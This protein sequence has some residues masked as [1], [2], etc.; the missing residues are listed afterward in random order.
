MFYTPAIWNNIS[1]HTIERV[2]NEGNYCWGK[3]SENF[4]I[5][6]IHDIPHRLGIYIPSQLWYLYDALNKRGDIDT[7][8]HNANEK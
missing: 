5:F 3:S 7:P 8:R 6:D 1:T 2:S 4:G